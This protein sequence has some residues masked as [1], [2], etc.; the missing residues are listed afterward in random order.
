MGTPDLI[1]ADEPYALSPSDAAARL[2]VNVATL[3]RNYGNA[4]R[5]GAIRS[6]KIGRARR[7][8]WRSLIDYIEAETAKA[9]RCPPTR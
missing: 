5:S 6:L 3:N 7:I 4:L 2:G 8:I 1:V 9:R